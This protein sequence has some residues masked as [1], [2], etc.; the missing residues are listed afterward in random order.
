MNLKI[1]E[2]EKY[3]QEDFEKIKLIKDALSES[4]LVNSSSYL[5]LDSEPLLKKDVVEELV[6]L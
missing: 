4:K 3:S 6:Y 1:K 5:I 2:L